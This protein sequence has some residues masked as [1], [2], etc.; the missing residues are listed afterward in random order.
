MAVAC[1]TMQPFSHPAGD[2]VSAW[3]RWAVLILAMALFAGGCATAPRPGAGTAGSPLPPPRID[4]SRPLH[5]SVDSPITHPWI[6]SDQVAE[7]FYM[8]VVSGFRAGGY[9]GNLIYVQPGR[10]APSGSQLL[11]LKIGEWRLNR[12]NSVEASIIAT[13]DAG[14]GVVRD[15]G[16]T[17][18]LS[19]HYLTAQNRP[20][21]ERAFDESAEGA[22]RQL[23]VKLSPNPKP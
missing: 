20:A 14:N 17:P 9:K 19:M 10:E 7:S 18:G 6:W 8:R 21:L 23:L 5:I 15:L 2:R 13:L 3:R 11:A 12:D 4:A 22:A 1:G 16:V